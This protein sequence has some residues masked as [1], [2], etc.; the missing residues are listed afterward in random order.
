MADLAKHLLC[1]VK[2]A[3]S[4]AAEVDPESVTLSPSLKQEIMAAGSI[5]PQIAIN[6]TAEPVVEFTTSDIKMVSTLTALSVVSPL[7]L[8]F[9]ALSDTFGYGTG[10]I[11]MTMSYG[12][13]EPVSITARRGQRSQLR[14]RVHL[15]SSD[16]DVSPVIVGTSSDTFVAPTD[17]YCGGVLTLG[18]AI[19]GLTDAGFEFGFRV[20]KNAG[21]NGLPYPTL[22]WCD[23][24]Q[25]ASLSASSE[26]LAYS[27][28]A[29]MMQATNETTVSLTFRKLNTAGIPTNSGGYSITASKVNV[30]VRQ[31]KGGRPASID[32]AA[33][34]VATD[35]AGTN[36]LQFANVA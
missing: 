17:F 27:T 28:Q 21:E 33:A 16:G 29:R 19:A 32:L 35:F 13:I 6:V 20:S 9:R 7:V 36:F 18:T 4:M 30:T 2:G 1:A 10:Y 23:Q 22:V 12:M 8:Y 15:T 26:A 11:S 3:G 31:V 34:C 25:A 24:P 14:V 5:Y